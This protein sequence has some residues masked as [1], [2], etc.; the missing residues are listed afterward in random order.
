MDAA[1]IVEDLHKRFGRV[2]ALDGFSLRVPERCVF[3]L[4]GPN[5][6]GKTTLFG[7]ACGFLHADAGRVEALGTDIARVG[8][9]TGR[10][11]TLPQDAQFQGNI[12]IVDQLVFFLRLQG[13]A[14]PAARREV[15]E[16]LAVVGLEEAARR[17][18]GT[19]SHG[20]HKRLA[21]AQA[22][23]GR[24]E[25]V[26]LDEPTAG[27]DPTHARD[28][29]DLITRMGREST[30]VVSS[31]NL[32][33]LETLCQ[34]VAV[35]DR[36]RLVAEGPVEELVRQGRSFALDLPRAPEPALRERIVAVPEV[37]DF[38]IGDAG[39]CQLDLAAGV[40]VDA[41]LGTV[42][43]TLLDAGLVPRSLSPGTNL[44]NEVLALLS[45]AEN[46]SR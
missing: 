38:R 34:R 31:H 29:C 45:G 26:L 39:R 32:G 37:A 41:V 4:I 9:L 40:E 12:P 19:L 8:E 43:R 1:L 17:R 23:L 44:E 42:L 27:L 28:V 14:T 7:I 11:G 35:M 33:Q 3:G 16:L 21:L 30:V 20:M 24:P 5:G 6:A 2:R 15:D 10:L 13:Y 36:G 22:F 18:A 25:L 46:G